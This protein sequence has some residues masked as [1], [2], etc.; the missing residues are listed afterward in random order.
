MNPQSGLNHPMFGINHT[1]ES[2]LKMSNSKLGIL[3]PMFNK[4][5]SEES[6]IKMRKPKTENGKLNIKAANWMRKLKSEETP[7]AKPCIINNKKF[8]CAKDAYKELNLN[9]SLCTFRARIRNG[10]NGWHY[11][12]V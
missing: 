6:L 8:G 5:K 7:S 11:L 3:N 10:Y 9:I 1:K 4:I 2:K 12:E